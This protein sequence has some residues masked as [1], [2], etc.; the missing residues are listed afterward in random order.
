MS[1]L[2]DKIREKSNDG[3]DILCKVLNLG[4]DVRTHCLNHNQSPAFANPD[5]SDKNHSCY[6]FYAQK[7]PPHQWMMKDHGLGEFARTWWQVYCDSRGLRDTQEDFGRNVSDLCAYM[8]YEDIVSSARRKGP[9]SETRFA[10]LDEQEGSDHWQAR[11]QM[12]ELELRWLFGPGVNETREFNGMDKA[13][14]VAKELGWISCEWFSHTGY[15]N[16]HGEVK[17]VIKKC[18]DDYMVF[19][20]SCR[21]DDGHVFYKIYRSNPESWVDREGK[22]KTEAK[23]QYSPKGS[24][25]P[26]YVNG[27][28]ELESNLQQYIAAHPSAKRLPEVTICSGERDALCARFYGHYPVWFNNDTDLPSGDM[29]S[30]INKYSDNIYLIPDVDGAGIKGG[31]AKALTYIDISTIWLNETSMAGINDRGKACKDF[32]D[33]VELHPRSYDINLLWRQARKAKFWQ[34]ETKDEKTKYKLLMVNMRYFLTLNGFWRYDDGKTEPVDI[35]HVD[36]YEVVKSSVSALYDFVNRYVQFVNPQCSTVQELVAKVQASDLGRLPSRRFSFKDCT[37]TS[38][39]I[40]FDNCI[41]NVSARKVDIIKR[42]DNPQGHYV[43]SQNIIHRDFKR[44]KDPCH[45]LWVEKDDRGRKKVRVKITMTEHNDDYG[46]MPWPV[47][48]VQGVYINSSRTEWRT[49]MQDPYN[50]PGLADEQEAYRRLHRFDLFG[51]N[52]NADQQQAQAESYIAKVFATG[53]LRHRE[54]LPSLALAVMCLDNKIDEEGHCNGRSGKSFICTFIS[55]QGMTVEP[56]DGRVKNLMSNPHVFGRVTRDTDVVFI[57]DINQDVKIMDFYTAIT[58]VMTVNPKN[59]D[60]F[61]LNFYESPK[62]LLSSNYVFSDLSSSTLERVQPETFADFYHGENTETGEARWSIRDDFGM[63]L[64][65]EQ[66]SAYYWN[67]DDN[68]LID[69]LQ[70]Y[71]LLLEEFGTKINP[72]MR[73]ILKRQDLETMGKHF[74]QWAIKYFKGQDKIPAIGLQPEQ[75]AIPSHLDQEVVKAEA[76]ASCIGTRGLEYLT[77]QAFITKLKAF[78]D[79]YDYELNPRE[80]CNR[81][82]DSKKPGAVKTLRNARMP[83]YDN[84]VEVLIMMDSRDRLMEYFANKRYNVTDDANPLEPAATPE[85]QSPV[86]SQ[87]T[88][89]TLD[90]PQPQEP[91]DDFV[92]KVPGCPF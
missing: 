75:A 63:D 4:E 91:T 69:C 57:D 8:G 76:Y 85:P 29:I 79:Y 26:N 59:R 67:C 86:T 25:A 46:A 24:K 5:Y 9:E 34:V 55:A 58:G 44:M 42:E 51:P 90:F 74:H 16:E 3:L 37:P 56:L 53:Y 13:R 11:E 41:V 17:T 47:S 60:G 12:T 38:Q 83:G 52:L 21:T 84:A 32:R 82:T 68:F 6:L 72:P 39:M 28:F 40:F 22:A 92:E 33:Y 36:G 10:T 48:N 7:N 64:L 45:R 19:V 23:C 66:Y 35:V 50:A 70:A 80:F 31:I 88:Q 73:N 54:K 18:S 78:A 2:K 15:H 77:S 20:R 62:F 81:A 1:E 61:S 65:T 71:F 43:W 27:L 14:E 30:S 49:E 87:P 89:Q